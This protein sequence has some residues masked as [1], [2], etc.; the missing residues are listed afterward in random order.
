MSSGGRSDFEET[1][2]DIIFDNV[3]GLDV[4]QKTI[5]VCV[6]KI[7]PQG[8][9][10]EEVRT[11]GTMTRDLLQ[12]SDWL[13]SEGVTHVAMEST[14][15]LWKPVWNILEGLFELLLVNPRELKQVP[16]RKSDVRDCQWIAHLLQCGLL[17]SS[18]VPPRAQREL[19]DLTRQRT[20]LLAEQTRAANRI[21][22]TLEDANIKLGAVAT[23]ILGKS[24]RAML[25][26]LVA[27][28]RDPA[29][30]A[31]LA[32]GKLRG[33]IPDLKSALQGHFTEHHCFML[34]SLLDHIE[35]LE[36][37]IELFS[38]RIEGCLRPFLDDEQMERLDAIPGVNRR[39]IENV[40]AEIG[41]DMSR[42]PHDNHL[43]SWAGMSPGNEE[44]AGKRMR[45]RTTKGNR[46][47][48]RAL[49]EAAWAA[50]RT[51]GSYLG[52]RYRRLAARRGK[53]RALI[54]VG[55]TILKIFYHVLSKDVDYEDLGVDY[56]DK[57]KPEQ[58]RRYLV[59]RLETL[60][61]DVTL[62]PKETA[63]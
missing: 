34:R 20:Q 39:T 32:V 13:A 16:G 5:M 40:V 28:Q 23:D 15:V 1:G 58:Y 49:T 37:Q 12:M 4:H 2:M 24:G 11:F 48:R 21:H 17:R 33:K 7:Q 42:F 22:K 59:K 44:S 51:K 54:A 62:T 35:Y 10:A 41:S 9:K 31:E 55:H 3:A 26:A 53:K 46:W 52:A 25:H 45:N 6:R 63:A 56:F 60:G 19:R 38:N 47:L 14:G 29:K 36:R 61:Y 57:L 50:S 27:G 18:F 43:S 8:G 30:L